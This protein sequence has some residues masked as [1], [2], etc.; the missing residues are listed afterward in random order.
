MASEKN[1]IGGVDRLTLTV[2]EAASLIGISRGLAYKL[3]RSGK[4]PTIRLGRRLLVPMASLKLM[5]TQTK[6]SVD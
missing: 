3:A 6:T 4:L 5:L 2:E 1:A